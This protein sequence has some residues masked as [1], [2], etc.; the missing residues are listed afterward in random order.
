[1]DSYVKVENF[2]DRPFVGKH[3][4]KPFRFAPGQSHFVPWEAA[5]QW[6]GD[7]NA[8]DTPQ[9]PLRTLTVA[10]LRT[11]YG[12]YNR[13]VKDRY[14]QFVT[15]G[16]T[17]GFPKLKVYD[18]QGVEVPMLLDYEFGDL[19]PK[20][21]DTPIDQAQ[22]MAALQAQL[23][24]L[25]A[26]LNLINPEASAVAH[27]PTVDGPPVLVPDVEP[28]VDHSAGAPEDGPP[29]PTPRPRAAAKG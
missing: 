4:M 23:E 17:V 3:D 13:E 21:P 15:D 28:A 14:E 22:V 18:A 7:P 29:V 27:V 1:M 2:G 5:V 6:L 11:L 12:V 9:L 19:K 10:R 16:G 8:A 24:A 25:Q 20:L 26:Q